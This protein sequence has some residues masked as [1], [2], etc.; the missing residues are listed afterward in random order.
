RFYQMAN[1]E[2]G[3]FPQAKWLDQWRVTIHDWKDDAKHAI[4]VYYEDYNFIGTELGK[5]PGEAER[6]FLY[7]RGFLENKYAEAYMSFIPFPQ[8]PDFSPAKPSPESKELTD[9]K[10]ELDDKKKEYEDQLKELKNE[11]KE[12]EDSLKD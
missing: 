7:H 12:M 3:L 4:K 1:Q 5:L 2:G 9:K 6:Q 11:K 8:G 10:K